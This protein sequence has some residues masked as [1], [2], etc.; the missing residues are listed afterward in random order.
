M[1][2]EGRVDGE[3]DHLHDA[4][5]DGRLRDAGIV[6]RKAD[7]AD[8]ARRLQLFYVF[9]VGAVHAQIPV[10]LCVHVVDHAEVD[11]VRAEALQQV[12]KG[13]LYELH[14]P[15]AHILAVLMGGADVTLHKPLFPVALEGFADDVPG[16]R[17]GHP[18]IDD[19]DALFLR[20]PDEFHGFLEL[21]AL[22]PLAAESDLAHFESGVS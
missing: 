3:E 18:A 9:D 13:R 10:L 12:L 15:G 1:H 5:F 6:G 8:G 21:V 16:L 17:I 14:V 4:G 19:V 20:V 11:V 22:Q 2:V 7:V